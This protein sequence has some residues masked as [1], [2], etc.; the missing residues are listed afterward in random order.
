LL[1]DDAFV[2]AF[3]AIWANRPPEGPTVIAPDLESLLGAKQLNVE[4]VVFAQSAGLAVPG[5]HLWMPV[6]LKGSIA[7]GHKEPSSSHPGIP[8]DRVSLSLPGAQPS[9]LINQ[10]S[11]PLAPNS[12]YRKYKLSSFLNSAC[13]VYEGQRVSRKRFIRDFA[14]NLGAAHIEWNDHKPQLRMLTESA[15]WLYVADRSAVVF[16]LLSIGQILVRS[17]AVGVFR[18]RLAEL[19]IE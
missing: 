18:S 15:E 3:N 6:A 17:R 12:C 13:I 7:K 19:G 10:D 1:A 4:D 2:K 16:E 14:N 8:A 5:M 9:G 11:V